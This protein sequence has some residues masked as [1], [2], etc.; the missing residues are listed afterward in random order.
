MKVVDYLK[1]KK[2][3]IGCPIELI[4][5]ITERGAYYGSYERC[6]D[7]LESHTDIANAIMLSDRTASERVRIYYICNIEWY[8]EIDISE[9]VDRAEKSIKERLDKTK[10]L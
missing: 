5:F 3:Y 8:S 9:A 1:G 10:C 4:N 7:D 2:E 6:L